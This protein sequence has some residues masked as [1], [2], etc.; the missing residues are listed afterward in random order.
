LKNFFLIFQCNSPT[1]FLSTLLQLTIIAPIFIITYFK[2][3]IVGLYAIIAVIIIGLFASISPQVLFGIK[4][5]LQ[6]WDLETVHVT[7]SKSFRW[8][9][10]TPNVYVTSFFV[11]IAFGYLMRKEISFSR[12]QQILF[13]ILSIVMILTV[14][15][16]HNNFWRLDK[17]APLWSVLLWHSIGKLL[18][19]SGFGWI[20]YMCCTGRGGEDL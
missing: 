4:P 11:G 3:P 8:Y 13:W 5:Y 20:F 19:S 18:F 16:W 17:S 14:Y 6:I 2:K 10:N 9:H 7:I 12:L 1:W 15:F